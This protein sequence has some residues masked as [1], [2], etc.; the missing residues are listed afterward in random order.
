MGFGINV[1][2]QWC[3]RIGILALVILAAFVTY[4]F[5][6]FGSE[7][8]VAFVIGYMTAVVC[9]ASTAGSK[10]LSPKTTWLY[11]SNFVLNN[12][13]RGAVIRSVLICF[14]SILVGTLMYILVS[15]DPTKMEYS[16][17]LY[18]GAHLLAALIAVSMVVLSWVVSYKI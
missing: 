18:F 17:E 8:G 7:E 9:G 16:W 14:S 10:S 3:N 15:F 5:R 4:P 1:G 2:E 11:K 13:Y 12:R 6:V